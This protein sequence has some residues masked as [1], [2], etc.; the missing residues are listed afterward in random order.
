MTTTARRGMS[1]WPSHESASRSYDSAI[2]PWKVGN[3]REGE[4]ELIGVREPRVQRVAGERDDGKVPIVPPGVADRGERGGAGRDERR[5]RET[6]DDRLVGR[7]SRNS[8]SSVAVPPATAGAMKSGALTP[9]S[10]IGGI[11]VCGR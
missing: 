3:D 1:E 4:I 9:V 10:I 8:S 6:E 5:G 7:S 2:P 11:C